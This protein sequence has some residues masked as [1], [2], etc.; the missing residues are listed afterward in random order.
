MTLHEWGVFHKTDKA[1]H[2]NFCHFY[3][4]RIG[5]PKRILEF[6]VL[7]GSSLKMWRDRYNARVTGFDIEK[8]PPISRIEIYQ[9]SCTDPGVAECW[10]DNDVDLIIDDASHKTIDQIAA[11][12]IWWPKVKEGGFLIVEDIHTMYYDEYNPTKICLKSWIESLG[13]KHEYYWRIP[14]MES[15]SG[16]VIF[17]K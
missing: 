12:K 4:E 9:A 15:D 10:P 14:G 17:Y 8:K 6:G 7:N 13:I 2:H 5:E 16:T 11:F 1:L 3:E